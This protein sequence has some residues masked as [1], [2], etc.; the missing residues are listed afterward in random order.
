VVVISNIKIKSGTFDNQ[1]LEKMI[2][3]Q[4]LTFRILKSN[5]R[6]KRPNDV[7]FC[8]TMNQ[9]KLSPDLRRR[10]IPI[11]L[12]SD[13]DPRT[14]RFKTSDLA[15]FV[16]D[17]RTLI[18]GELLGM[19]EQWKDRGKPI[20]EPAP[21]HSMGQEWAATVNGILEANDLKGFLSNFEESVMAFDPDMETIQTICQGCHGQE[22]RIPS[23]WVPELKHLLPDRLRMN[24]F[25]AR[26]DHALAT[27]VG[28]LF[29]K[30]E[31]RRVLVGEQSYEIRKHDYGKG[32]SAKYQILKVKEQG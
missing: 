26:S 16:A 20:P 22:A 32:H 12:H 1:V 7:I 2:T 13:V 9:T 18:L 25:S 17:N 5:D 29:S 19:V 8:L 3:D 30:F 4:T 14:R 24:G 11:N 23:E 31:G 6:F 10:Q 27:V 28:S 21:G 15:Q